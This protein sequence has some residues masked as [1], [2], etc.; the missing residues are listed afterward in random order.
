LHL[1]L[2]P[3]EKENK[4]KIVI[5][6]NLNKIYLRKKEMIKILFMK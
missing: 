3:N 5:F 4:E 1:L 6:H 2:Y